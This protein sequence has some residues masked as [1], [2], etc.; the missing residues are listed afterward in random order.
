MLLNNKAITCTSTELTGCTPSTTT[1]LPKVEKT[2]KKYSNILY[3]GHGH[4]LVYIRLVPGT[5]PYIIVLQV[6]IR[7]KGKI[8]Q[9]FPL[10]NVSTPL[11]SFL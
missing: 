6:L 7:R 10:Q 11:T 4:F 8:G 1:K 3:S 2:H 9:D 5:I